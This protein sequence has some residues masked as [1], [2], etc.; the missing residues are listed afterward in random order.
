MNERRQNKEIQKKAEEK[1]GVEGNTGKIA[2]GIVAAVL[3]ILT[4]RGFQYNFKEQ[5][6]GIDCGC[7]GNT[8]FIQMGT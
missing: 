6:A 4:L 2:K 3:T 8:I 5:L 1:D 7:S